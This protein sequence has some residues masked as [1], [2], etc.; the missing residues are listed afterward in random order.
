M[1][2]IDRITRIF[3][4]IRLIIDWLRGPKH[5]R[6]A[7]FV[8]ICGIGIVSS[9]IWQPYFVA[10]ADIIF[11]GYFSGKI[12]HDD[13]VNPWIGVCIIRFGLVYHIAA[14]RV[15]NLSTALQNSVDQAFFMKYLQNAWPKIS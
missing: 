4:K 9:K 14:T 10:L 8:I 3:G 1:E 6:L 2:W 15:T 11:E 13:N 12:N 7:S 5:S